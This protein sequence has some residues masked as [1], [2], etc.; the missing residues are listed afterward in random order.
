MTVAIASQRNFQTMG[1]ILAT[2]SK[3]PTLFPGPEPP[4][5]SSALQ[6]CSSGRLV[7]ASLL[8]FRSAPRSLPGLARAVVVPC[9]SGTSLVM[10]LGAVGPGFGRLPHRQHRPLPRLLPG[11]VEARS[12]LPAALRDLAQRVPLIHGMEAGPMLA[13]GGWFRAA[14]PD[15]PLGV[16]GGSSVTQGRLPAVGPLR[17]WGQKPCSFR[18]G[19][20]R[21]DPTV[22]PFRQGTPKVLDRARGIR[23]RRLLQTA[24]TKVPTRPNSRTAGKARALVA[25]SWSPWGQLRVAGWWCWKTRNSENSTQIMA[26]PMSR[27]MMRLAAGSTTKNRTKRTTKTRRT[28]ESGCRSRCFICK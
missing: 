20:R 10:S 27:W 8:G 11:G 3:R 4:G 23:V 19:P 5:V 15:H 22:Q 1:P 16:A 14:A 18:P 13:Q 6:T 26:S 12:R 2:P 7:S 25:P 9:G 17:T 28:A 24:T 21:S